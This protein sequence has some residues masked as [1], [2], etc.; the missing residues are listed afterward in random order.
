MKKLSAKYLQRKNHPIWLMGLSFIGFIDSTYLTWYHYAY[1]FVPCEAGGCEVV[2]TSKY[3]EI[4]G[5]P[6][7]GLGAMYYLTVFLGA[8]LFLK[9]KDSFLGIKPQRILNIVSHLT[10][11]G[12]VTSIFLVYIQLAILFSI[13]PY[14]MFSAATSTLMFLI[15]I[16]HIFKRS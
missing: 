9:T 11:V 15:S 8:L 1:R 5:F 14:C 6:T 12:I 7:A 3:S 10:I 13:C 2:L 16:P 4:F